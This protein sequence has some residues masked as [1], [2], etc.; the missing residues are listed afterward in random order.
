MSWLR[1]RLSIVLLVLVSM[2]Y[3]YEPLAEMVGWTSRAWFY[4]FQGLTGAV[5]FGVVGVLA[6]GWV[7]LGLCVVGCLEQCLVAGCRL[8][9][10]PFPPPAVGPTE[11]IC[12]AQGINTDLLGLAALLWFA[13]ILV[14]KDRKNEPTDPQP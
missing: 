5:L 8:A 7:P 10:F 14:F 9:Q 13:I 12:K 11:G 6:R 1:P 3:A 4:V 2:H